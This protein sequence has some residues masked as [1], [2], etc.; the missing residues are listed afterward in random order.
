[1]GYKFGGCGG[2]CGLFFPRIK[3][4][5]RSR[6]KEECDEKKREKA[7]DVKDKENTVKS[8]EELKDEEKYFCLI[9]SKFHFSKMF[10][11]LR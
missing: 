10:L 2:V 4:L 11:F 3:T 7:L 1:M 8:L 6:E 5:E 9:R